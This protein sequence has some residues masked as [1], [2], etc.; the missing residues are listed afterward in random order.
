[1]D[2]FALRGM[3]P[4]ELGA[5]A[6]VSPTADAESGDLGLGARASAFRTSPGFGIVFRTH[7]L[8]EA[9]T[10]AAANVVEQRHPSRSLVLLL[11]GRKLR[12]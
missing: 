10:A 3:A 8:L 11:K 2:V 6:E 1:M 4:M 12:V 5:F 7:E 9:M